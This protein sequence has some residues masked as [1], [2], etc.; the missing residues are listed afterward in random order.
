MK[1]AIDFGNTLAKIGLFENK[2]LI[3]VL[4]FN[5]ENIYDLINYLSIIKDLDFI[6]FSSVIDI[7]EQNLNK[8][9]SFCKTIEFSN[10]TSIP[11][12]NKYK[13]PET[14]GKDRLASAVAGNYLYRN[15]NTLIIDAGTCIKYDFVNNRNEYLGGSISPG[16]KMRFSA[17]NTFTDKLPLVEY[18]F[19]KKLIGQTTQEAIISGVINGLI[20]EIDGIINCYHHEYEDLQIIMSGGDL[21]Y[22]D[23]QLKSSIFAVENIVLKGLNEILDYNVENKFI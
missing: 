10:K 18:N 12:V 22:F 16:I 15:K 4:T 19:E 17:L 5:K 1:I 23:K 21:K 8:I 2:N 9:K 20:S 3:N 14:L 7:S 13:T 6:I 11:V